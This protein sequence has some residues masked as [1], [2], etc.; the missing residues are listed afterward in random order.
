MVSLL[1]IP[2]YNRKTQIKTKQPIVGEDKL[3]HLHSLN[4]MRT[5]TVYSFSNGNL[6]IESQGTM[7]AESIPVVQQIN[8]ETRPFAAPIPHPMGGGSAYCRQRW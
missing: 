6:L 3:L 2:G 5:E 7:L 8:H 1:G 4:K